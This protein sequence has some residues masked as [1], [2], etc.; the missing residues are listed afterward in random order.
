MEDKDTIINI[1]LQTRNN[2]MDQILGLQ[3]R[4]AKME[5]LMPKEPANDDLSG[6]N[7]QRD[8]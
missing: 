3:L 7:V 4:I 2:L 8:S 5:P 6:S 1:L